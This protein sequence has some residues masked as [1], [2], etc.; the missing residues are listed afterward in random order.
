M[1]M[2][3]HEFLK[4]MDR[5]EFKALLKETLYELSERNLACD[6][7]GMLTIK[8]ASVFLNLAVSTIYEKTSTRN[9]PQ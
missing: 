6:E 1:K 4:A 5:E 8:Q 9:I 7:D 2:G 3:P